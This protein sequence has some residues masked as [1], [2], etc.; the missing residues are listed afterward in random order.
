MVAPC[1]TVTSGNTVTS[2]VMGKI[3]GMSLKLMILSHLQFLVI[4]VDVLLAALFVYIV[5]H[6]E[7]AAGA[8]E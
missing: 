3:F 6:N 4:L 1:L 2:Y 7:L 8:F 5:M